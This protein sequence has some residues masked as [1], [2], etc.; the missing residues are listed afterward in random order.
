MT[1]RWPHL[2]VVAIAAARVIIGAHY[3]S[4]AMMGLAIGAAA[5]EIVVLRRLPLKSSA[6]LLGVLIVAVSSLRLRSRQ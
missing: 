2:V 1:R 5:T 3:L 6:T 4:D